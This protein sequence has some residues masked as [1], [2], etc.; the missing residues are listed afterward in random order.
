MASPMLSADYQSSHKFQATGWAILEAVA[1]ERLFFSYDVHVL[2]RWSGFPIR[3]SRNCRAGCLVAHAR[4]TLLTCSTPYLVSTLIR[5]TAAGS[6][7]INFE[8]LSE[9]PYYLSF[10]LWVSRGCC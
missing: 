7:W 6:P 3:S 4:R 9:I 5:F 8:L 1:R 2:A 10:D